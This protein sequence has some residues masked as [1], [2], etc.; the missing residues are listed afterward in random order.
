ML[1]ENIETDR[2]IIRR[3]SKED[4]RDLYEYL[5]QEEVVKYEPYEVL[6]EEGAKE[7]ANYRSHDDAFWAVCLK[8]NNKLIGNIYFEQQDPKEFMTWEIGYVFNPK[9]YGKGYATEA[10]KRII[11]YSFEECDAHR[12]IAM[13]NPENIPSWKVMERLN[14]RRE[15]H[16]KKQAFFK[17]SS[18]GKPLWH[19]S[20][21]YA[22]LKEEFFEK[23][24]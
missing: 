14:M 7:E 19:D 8:D 12:I 11:Q 5:S 20:Y 24:K 9:Y 22:I 23:Y 18:K 4:W 6:S 10:C 2:L 21:L 13:C 16:L 17:V 1:F 15:G 3:F